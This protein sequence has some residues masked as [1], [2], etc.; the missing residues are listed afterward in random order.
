MAIREEGGWND[1]LPRMHNAS[2]RAVDTPIVDVSILMVGI[3]CCW[4]AFV[5]G[6]SE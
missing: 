1:T 3:D 6:W 4:L 2:R 5:V